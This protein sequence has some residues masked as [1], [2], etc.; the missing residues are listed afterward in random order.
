MIV[1]AALGGGLFLLPVVLQVVD[2]YT[3]LE[4]GM[5]LLPLTIVM[6]LL[7]SLS[8]R[9]ASRIGPR[10]QMSVGP[11]VVAAGLVLFTRI[12]SDSSYLSGVLPGVLVFALGLAITVAPLTATALGSVADEHAGLASAVNNDVARVGQLI[13]TAVLPPV[14]GI[15]GA[16]YLHPAVLADGF[17]KAIFIAA[18]LCA[19]GGLLA[20]AGIRNPA[21][22]A[23]KDE[24]EKKRP[25]PSSYFHC[26]LDGAPLVAHE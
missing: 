2:H 20:A 24:T 22:P 16:A 3:P 8:G 10:L 19:A 21:R 5:S 4:S 17:H 1:Y 9:L 11:V 6:L 18:S 23:Q 25:A 12:T 13:A 14:A 15:T 7:S 26:A